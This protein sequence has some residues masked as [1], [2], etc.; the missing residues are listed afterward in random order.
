MIKENNGQ[1]KRRLT[2]N[3]AIK[4]FERN[5]ITEYNGKTI[6]TNIR[7]DVIDIYKILTKKKKVK[8]NPKDVH[9]KYIHSEQWIK[10]RKRFFKNNPKECYICKCTYNIHLHHSTYKNLHT[11]KEIK[12]LIPLCSIHHE[13]LHKTH[14]KGTDLK[15][16]TIQFISNNL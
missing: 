3:R 1:L 8:S 10:L 15:K 14:V 6:N 4:Y 5:N 9:N 7:K 12:D 2:Y 16:H 11:K 13:L